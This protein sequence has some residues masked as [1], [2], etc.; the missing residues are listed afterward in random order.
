MKGKAM[1]V[2]ESSKPD[3]QVFSR[4]DEGGDIGTLK[5]VTKPCLRGL[6]RPKNPK[7]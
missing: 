1:N 4:D 3:S 2:A 5:L 7:L 6:T